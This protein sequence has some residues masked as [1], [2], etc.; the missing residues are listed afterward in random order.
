M[1]FFLIGLDIHYEAI[2]A[3]LLA[4]VPLPSLD[5]AYNSVINTERMRVKG[6]KE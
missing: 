1:R 4:Q 5:E 6:G 2:R 3:Q